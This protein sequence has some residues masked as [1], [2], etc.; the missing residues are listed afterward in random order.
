VALEPGVTL[1]EGVRVG[2]GPRELRA[3]LEL[4]NTKFLGASLVASGVGGF[5]DLGDSMLSWES[6]AGASGSMSCGALHKKPS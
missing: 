5:S 6:L 2:I 3:L 1:A 4:E